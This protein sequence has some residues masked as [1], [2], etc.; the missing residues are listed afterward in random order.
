[1]VLLSLK[2][3]AGFFRQEKSRRIYNKWLNTVECE[4]P[5]DAEEISLY[6]YPR[7]A[8]ICDNLLPSPIALSIRCLKINVSYMED[9]DN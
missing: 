9:I 2:K 6:M 8:P 1:M 5:L 3:S 7:E 4:A